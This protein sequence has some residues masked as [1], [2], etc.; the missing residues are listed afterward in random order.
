MDFDDTKE[1]AAFRKECYDWLSQNARLKS[2]SGENSRNRSNMSDDE[3][4]KR[5]KEW[6]AKKAAA[7]YAQI[8]WPKEWGGRGGTPIESVIYSQE[9]AKFS[10]P[11][12]VF[13]IGLGMCVPT[14]MTYA[15]P[16]TCKRVVGPA[17]RGEEIWCQL[18]SEPAAGSDVAGIRTK[19]EK[20]GDEWV[21][22]GQKVWT[23]GAQ[24]SDFG[25]IITRTDPNV[26]KHKGLTMFWL[27]MKSPGVE[28][29]PIKQMSG[30]SGFNEVFFTDVRVKDSQRLGE[31][32]QGWKSAI[33]TL[34]NERLAVG[35]GAGAGDF[36][37]LLALA[38]STEMEEGAAIAQ[39]SVREKI[40]DWYVES[41]GLKL[42]RFRT[43]TALSKGTAPGPE[44]SIGKIV[45]APK[46]Q[47]LAAFA[48]DMEDMGGII[49]DRSIAPLN[50][51]FQA[52][53]F[54][55]AGYRIAG[56]TDEILRNIVAERVLGLPQD[57]RV[58]KDAAFNELPK[59]K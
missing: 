3:L 56:G 30:D 26:P 45:S 59:G 54:G 52:Q 34:M 5:A 21:I 42:N 48:M 33:T 25:I 22:N 4:V 51:G 57:V 35:G 31:V 11:G 29:R 12:G 49:T 55:A 20:D 44:A 16:E 28:V 24:F 37:E 43:I 38:R 40:A 39:S 53:W 13:E 32:G 46:M 36:G 10:V 9:E 27:D 15:D 7:G 17:L 18:F 50:G 14:V 8:T 1:E 23:S 6:Q 58:D 19:A 41:Q 47:D 2:A